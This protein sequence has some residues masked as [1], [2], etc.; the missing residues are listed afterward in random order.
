M[1]PNTV[2]IVE[3]KTKCRTV[4]NV[5]SRSNSVA[6]LHR[7]LRMH[8]ADESRSS[9]ATAPRLGFCCDSMYCYVS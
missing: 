4:Y 9:T 1:L 2:N 8:Y 6:P 7:R 3:Q 5:W